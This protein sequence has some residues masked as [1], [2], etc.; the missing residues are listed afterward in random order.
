MVKKY[1]RMD[2]KCQYQIASLPFG[3]G[4]DLIL[5]MS[6]K[7]EIHSNRKENLKFLIDEY[8]K[9]NAAAFAE[10]LC[11]QRPQIYRVF[12][13]A[14]SARNVGEDTARKIEEKMNIKP[15][16]MDKKHDFSAKKSHI[17]EK[18]GEYTEQDEEEIKPLLLT[19]IQKELLKLFDQLTEDQQK[20][21]LDA[22]KK[23]AD[24][25][26]KI[27]QEMLKKQRRTINY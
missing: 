10:T 13:T 9:G 17:K 1:N 18:N 6:T 19:E 11:I 2:S 8:F 14:K 22:I 15:F 4:N 23:Q 3:N 24:E 16:W 5:N 12:S 26:H 25:N 27:M 20:E 7:S 21:M